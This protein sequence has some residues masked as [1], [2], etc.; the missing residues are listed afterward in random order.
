MAVLLFKV[1]FGMDGNIVSYGSTVTGKV[2]E[3]NEDCFY[4]NGIVSPCGAS[5]FAEEKSTDT[6][7]QIFAVFD[8]MGG[9]ACGEIASSL[10]A[11]TLAKVHEKFTAENSEPLTKLVGDFF[12]N[13]SSAV[14]ER[15]KE[16]GKAIIGTTCALACFYK[17]KLFAANIGDSRSYYYT[18]GRLSQISKDHT[19]A[20]Y[21]I[22]K[23]I[24]SEE[25]ARTSSAK[26]GL[27]RFL[28]MPTD[29]QPLAAYYSRP[30]VPKS[31]DVLIMCSDGLT[32]MLYDKD[33]EEIIKEQKKPKK[34]GE[35]LTALAL[36]RG[37]VDN[38]TVIVL[39]F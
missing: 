33:I 23:G 38:T 21:L 18:D 13:A 9:E 28:G 4:L 5:E 2:R 27:M 17:G 12:K 10:A 37:G 31:G 11:E 39:R 35:K 25:E 7:V 16:L 32:D 22:D 14:E 34:I 8:G 19:E 6:A 20:Q 3:N 1:V 15:A 30:A 26:H 24:M 36:E 29:F